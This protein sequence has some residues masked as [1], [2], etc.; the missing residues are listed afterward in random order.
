[1]RWNC[2]P[3][4][5]DAMMNTLPA[6]GHGF[7]YRYTFRNGKSYIGQ[8]VKTLRE[9]TRNHRRKNQ[10]VD[11]VIRSGAEF[12]IDILAE[13]PID[14][15]D[16]VERYCIAYFDTM[17]PNGYNYLIGGQTYGRNLSDESKKR[18]GE[19]R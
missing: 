13:V 16:A 8:T 15:L 4:F 12:S 7:I 6:E 1:M 10:N 11:L 9:R 17:V 2:T 3:G 5:G 18:I 19:K 14:I